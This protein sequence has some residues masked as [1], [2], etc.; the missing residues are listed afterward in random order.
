VNTVRV[1]SHLSDRWRGSVQVHTPVKHSLIYT[2]GKKYWTIF[3]SLQLLHMTKQE[4][5]SLYIFRFILSM[6]PYLNI[7]CT[8]SDNTYYTENNN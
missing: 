6:L 2:I 8:S 4:G 3:R 7:L 5:A 1:S